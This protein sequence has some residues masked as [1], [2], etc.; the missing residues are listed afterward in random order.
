MIILPSQHTVHE[1]GFVNVT[2]DVLDNYTAS[3]LWKRED[4]DDFIQYGGQLI[5]YEVIVNAIELLRIKI[6]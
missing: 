4:H 5:L 2:C 3:F 6:K 1:L